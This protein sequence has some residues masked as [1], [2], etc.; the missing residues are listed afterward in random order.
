[1]EGLSHRTLRPVIG[2]EMPLAD[3]PEAHRAVLAVTRT[4]RSCL[5]RKQ[6]LGR[7]KP[8]PYNYF[9]LFAR[10]SPGERSNE[11]KHLTTARC[12]YSFRS[13]LS[14]RSSPA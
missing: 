5:S 7:D 6:V 3:A 9:L 1:V 12:F 10:F 14:S 4:A 8:S 11:G 13:H 2:A